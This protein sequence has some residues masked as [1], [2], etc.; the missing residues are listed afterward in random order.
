MLN[1]YEGNLNKAYNLNITLIIIYLSLLTICIAFYAI[2]QLYVDDKSTA[3]NLMIW[4]ATLFPSIALLYTF[5]YWRKQKGSEVLSKLS[6]EVFFTVNK[7]SKIHEEI[8]DDHR[9]VLL[10]RLFNKNEMK[11]TEKS[12]YLFETIENYMSSIGENSFLIVEYTRDDNLKTCLKEMYEAYLNYNNT[13]INIYLGMKIVEKTETR[14]HSVAF[15]KNDDLEYHN[16]IEPNKKASIDLT[17]KMSKLSK[18]LLKY[19]FYAN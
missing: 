17:I 10:D 15:D 5:N 8:Y 18:E 2:I 6:E 9:E 16:H 1:K 11:E 12:K 7:A 13:R 4:S 14:L 19:I 3:T